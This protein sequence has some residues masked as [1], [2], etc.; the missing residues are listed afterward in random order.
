MSFFHN[1]EVYK[2]YVEEQ[3]FIKSMCLDVLE[4]TG[5]LNQN[6]FSSLTNFF[7]TT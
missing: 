6:A 4:P 1:V 3:E 5:E 7:S 2:K